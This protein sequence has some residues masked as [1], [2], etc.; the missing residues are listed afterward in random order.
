MFDFLDYL[1][2]T[3]FAYRNQ[4]FSQEDQLRRIVSLVQRVSDTGISQI[5]LVIDYEVIAFTFGAWGC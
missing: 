4:S 3:P 2:G 5:S 1:R